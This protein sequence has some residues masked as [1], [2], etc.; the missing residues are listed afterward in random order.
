MTNDIRYGG[1]LGLPRQTSPDGTGGILGQFFAPPAEEPGS[2]LWPINAG[3]AGP[4]PTL[5]LDTYLSPM[6]PPG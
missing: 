2:N 4:P 5:G 3:G 1:L 6:P